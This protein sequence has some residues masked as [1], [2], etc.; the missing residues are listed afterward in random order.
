MLN[1]GRIRIPCRLGEK[2]CN[3]EVCDLRIRYHPASKQRA[4]LTNS[5]LL[6]DL[7]DLRAAFSA[8]S[9]YDRMN[10]RAAHALNIQCAS[11]RKRFS[12]KVLPCRQIFDH[13]DR[14]HSEVT[15]YS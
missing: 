11:H 3:G 2:A 4:Y 5:L 14:V 10:E 12:L 6:A 8:P 1:R 15:A 9:T 13:D 7:D